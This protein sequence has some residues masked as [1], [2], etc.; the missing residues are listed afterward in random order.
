MREKDSHQPKG[1][2]IFRWEPSCFPKFD[3]SFIFKGCLTSYS[4]QVKSALRVSV[5]WE[6]Q[7]GPKFCSVHFPSSTDFRF[8]A[9]SQF[10][11]ICSLLLVISTYYSIKTIFSPPVIP[12]ANVWFSLNLLVAHLIRT[13]LEAYLKW[14]QKRTKC[15]AEMW[16]SAHEHQ[17]L[18]GR[19]QFSWCKAVS[20]HFVISG[21][22]GINHGLFWILMNSW[23]LHHFCPLNAVLNTAI[24]MQRM[25]KS[26]LTERTASV[27]RIKQTSA[28]CNPKEHHLEPACLGHGK[29]LAR[30]TARTAAELLW[31]Y[32]I[33]KFKMMVEKDFTLAYR[34]HGYLTGC[35]NL[36]QKKGSWCF[37]REEGEEEKE[38]KD[39][40][41]QLFA[42]DS[43]KKMWRKEEWSSE[44]ATRK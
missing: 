17:S 29:A 9:G 36:Q 20:K 33:L 44:N 11:A 41:S 1:S 23:V 40:R 27:G 2:L 15:S 30:R 35:I 8:L 37:L 26:C 28:D 38:R 7:H 43:L 39:K 13:A 24:K 10:G 5:L 3:H 4:S 25:D 42:P 31:T 22:S 34:H 16:A 14:E 19:K 12:S 6:V 18:S 32:H 21:L